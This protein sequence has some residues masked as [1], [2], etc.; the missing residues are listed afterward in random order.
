MHSLR[1]TWNSYT[2]MAKHSDSSVISYSEFLTALQIV[3][4]YAKQISLHQA[5]IQMDMDS[6]SR[7][8]SVS[9]QTM[10]K[11]ILLSRR[12]MNV[13]G[14]LNDFDLSKA[15]I[16]DLKTL[17]RKKLLTQSNLGKRTMFEIEELCLYAG[18]EM[19]P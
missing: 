19:L 15:T 7:F 14:N 3:K 18:I 17:S 5:Y 10:I 9:D 8:L 11:D 4:R 12:T 2:I 13:L 1:E 16:S 6:V